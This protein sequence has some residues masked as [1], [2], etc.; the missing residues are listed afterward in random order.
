MLKVT[1]FGGSSLCDSAAFAR[2][3]ELVLADP[4]RRVVVVSAPG[5][6]H[7]ADHKITDLLYL[8]HAHLQYG[9]SCWDL[10]RR[11]SDRFREI[12][13]GCAVACPIE[14]TLEEIYAAFGPNTP[15]DWIASRGEYLAAQLMAQLLG[16]TFVDAKDWLL[17]DAQGRVRQEASYAALRSLADGRKIVTPGFYGAA[18][19]GAVHTLSRGGSDVTGALAAAA[20][21]ADLYEN[22]TDVP[23]V[24]AADPRI[25]PD[26]APVPALRYGEVHMLAQ[27]GMQVLHED[28]VAPVAQAQI[29]LRICSVRAP[30]AP[31][32]MVCAQLPAEAGPEAVCF[33]GRRSLAMLRVSGVSGQ[34][35]PARLADICREAGIE[36]FSVQ[37]VCGGVTAL[38]PMQ[39][40][41]AALCRLQDEICAALHGARCTLRENLSVIAC[42]CRHT[43]AAPAAAL[44]MEAAGVPVHHQFTAD[45][46]AFLTVNDSQYETALRAA[47][48]ARANAEN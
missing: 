11:V 35:A 2:V 9:V 33:A 7:A 19:D 48:A 5:K 27:T 20:L 25:V 18:P 44:A 32:T 13:D 8:C 39:P 30:E 3:R 1:K 34:D 42:L 17:F 16:F 22:W 36:P 10:W 6:R 41:S 46:C 29:P 43:R 47:Y 12:R 38:L 24:L 45:G 37:S 23:G 15:Q 21:R 26:P 4:A 14:R 40:G 28:A 31:G